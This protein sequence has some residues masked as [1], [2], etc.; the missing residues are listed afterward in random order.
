MN[1]GFEGIFG[2]L[3]GEFY[4]IMRIPGVVNAIRLFAVLANSVNSVVVF[5]SLNRSRFISSPFR[6]FRSSC[7]YLRVR[8]VLERP[9]RLKSRRRWRCVEIFPLYTEAGPL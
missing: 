7:P 9:F 8:L 5:L 6:A 3:V 1:L 2:A 4:K